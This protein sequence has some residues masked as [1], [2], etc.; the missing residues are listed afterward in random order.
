MKH[1]G[2]A[3]WFLEELLR[4]E[5]SLDF[6][7]GWK[8]Q[9]CV[10]RELDPQPCTIPSNLNRSPSASPLERPTSG[11]VWS[12]YL[13][14]CSQR[15][16]GWVGPLAPRG[17]FTQRG[18]TAGAYPCYVRFEEGSLLKA[19]LNNPKRVGVDAAHLN[20]VSASQVSERLCN[21]VAKN[22]LWPESEGKKKQQD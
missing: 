13:V 6:W 14:T 12:H 15:G 4:D 17:T 2:P 5:P 3:A 18:A 22:Q 19:S 1:P 10:G 7:G 21:E 8:A 20:G 16:Q 11:E 9:E